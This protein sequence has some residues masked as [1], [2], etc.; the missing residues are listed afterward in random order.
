MEAVTAVAAVV[1]G[2][3]VLMGHIRV[4]VYFL[5]G[6]TPKPT[7]FQEVLHLAIILLQMERVRVLSLIRMVPESKHC[8]FR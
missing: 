2:I 4:P 7:Q 3:I 5:D 1:V 8:D 6:H